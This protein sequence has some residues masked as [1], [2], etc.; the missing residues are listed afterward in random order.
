MNFEEVKQLVMDSIDESKNLNDLIHIVINKI[1]QKGFN[2]GRDCLN[3]T[4]YEGTDEKYY[5]KTW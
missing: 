4:M 1:Y 5:P 2:D 3:D